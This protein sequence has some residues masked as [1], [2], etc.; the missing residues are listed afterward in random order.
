MST[1]L[2]PRP[3]VKRRSI[4]RQSCSSRFLWERR[5]V[6]QRFH[7][8]RALKVSA[9]PHFGERHH[10]LFVLRTVPHAFIAGQRHADSSSR[11]VARRRCCHR[12]DP[13]S[14][15][16]ASSL[17]TARGLNTCRRC[18]LAAHERRTSTAKHAAAA[19]PARRSRSRRHSRLRA[20]RQHRP[21]SG[22]TT[23]NATN[24]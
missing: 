12:R 14:R 13:G 19:A 7:E 18:R 24:A 21:C 15:W 11:D 3:G 16:L 9:R 22:I 20:R 8:G 2:D 4:L 17:R 5:G 6:P 10:L 1:S 23:D